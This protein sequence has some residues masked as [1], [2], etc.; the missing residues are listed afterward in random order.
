MTIQKQIII[1]IGGI[2]I[3]LLLQSDAV[4]KKIKSRYHGYISNSHVIPDLTI[5]CT[6]VRKCPKTNRANLIIQEDNTHTWHIKRADFYCSWQNKHGTAVLSQSIY[7]IDGLLRV[8]I[9]MIA[10]AKNRLLIHAA[11]LKKGKMGYILAGPSGAGK[12][13]SCRLAGLSRVL[14]DEIVCAGFDDTGL[15][16]LWATPFWGALGTGPITR[17]PRKLASIWF[18]KKSKKKTRAI[19][20]S[21]TEGIAKFLRCCCHFTNDETSVLLVLDIVTRLVMQVPAATLQFT[22][23]NG[24]LEVIEG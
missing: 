14:N 3:A 21:L 12:T 11:G 8:L 23:D 7:A 10:P 1:S 24:F 5:S 4:Y 13:T 17:T 9:S 16:M 22:K 18:L 19:P 15:P 2:H 6:F 20:I